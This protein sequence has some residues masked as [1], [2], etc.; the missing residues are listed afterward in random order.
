[1]HAF[2]ANFDGLVGPTHNYA[3]LSYGNVASTGNGQRTANPRLAARQGLDKMKALAD[4]GFRQGVL[5]PHERPDVASLRQL[6]FA[7]SDAQVIAR[8]AREA[9][10]VLAA[11]SSA[12]PMWTANAA[13]VSPSADSADGRVHFT[14][15]NLN[16]KFHR[17]IEH[18]TTGRVLAATFADPRCFAH[19][20]A[21][22]AHMAFGDEGAAN[23]T[24]LCA[25]YGAP[26]VQ[27]FVYGQRAF[28]AS[29][30]GPRRYPARQT[31]E[32]SQAVARQHGLNPARVV[33]AQQAPAAIDAGVFHNDVIAVG[34]RDVLFY[35]QHAFAD[36]DATL[37]A[38]ADAMH[39]VGAS[40]RPL[41]VPAAAV[42]IEDAVRSYL[43]NSQLLSR[44]DGRMLL[45]VPEECRHVE[46]VW[47]YLQD[48]LASQGPIAEVRVFDLKQ[49]MQNGGGPACLRLRVALTADECAA[50][51]PAVWINDDRYA[52]LCAWVDRHYRDRLS[53]DDLADP[54]L[55]QECRTALDELTQLLQLGSIYPFQRG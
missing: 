36:A 48:L 12:S 55:L 41:Q 19:H 2:E 37:A 16:N 35:H 49:S 43:F 30:N 46:P 51:N 14:P 15:A 4:L 32:A 1:M 11:C 5:A 21:L 9:P 33:F 13:T 28:D 22:P 23:H 38:L 17:A 42:S 52:S 31:L 44:A 6:G 50:V 10:A 34:N 29:A 53:A 24:R 20:P 3:G 26:G 54:Q 39:G 25:D 8:A 7:G 27:L 47:A 45:V 18:P 40:L